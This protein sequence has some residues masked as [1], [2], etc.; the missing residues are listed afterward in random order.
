MKPADERKKRYNAPLHRKRKNL[1]V[2]V[3]KELKKK[4][5]KKRSII[6]KKG[7]KV[8]VMNGKHKGKE[9]KVARVNHRD[10]KVYLEGLAKRTARGREMAVAFQPSNL[11]LTALTER[12]N[13]KEL[14]G[15]KNTKN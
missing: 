14:A 15:C 12:K 8:K 5:I 13:K 11:Q 3:S 6:V 7:D 1:R 4:D 2:H 9:A 10:A